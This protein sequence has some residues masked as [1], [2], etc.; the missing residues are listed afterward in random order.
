M[1][2]VTSCAS[3]EIAH[4]SSSSALYELRNEKDR[5]VHMWAPRMTILRRAKFSFDMASG[6]MVSS[7]PPSSKSLHSKHCFF[8]APMLVSENPLM[9]PQHVADE[10]VNQIQSA[11]G[12]DELRLQT[13]FL[14]VN[15]NPRNGLASM[16]S[17]WMEKIMIKLLYRPPSEPNP[18]L[19]GN[20]AP[21]VDEAPITE[22]L[23]IHGCLPDCL[24]GEF[25]GFGPNPKFT[26]VAGYHWLSILFACVS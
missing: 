9:A 25:M 7:V 10:V 15:P 5:A 23:T 13:C 19:S 1:T 26:P 12:G 17:D 16:A 24:N 21:V 22:N 6:F 20:F 14:E 11:I 4:L 3:M 18:F 2:S 8:V